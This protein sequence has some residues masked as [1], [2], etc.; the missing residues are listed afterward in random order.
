MP[1]KVRK[2]VGWS[3]VGLLAL[4]I[5]LNLE[6]VPIN[7]FFVVRSHMPVAVVIFLSAAMGAGAVY[8]FQFLRTY[9]KDK[10]PP[11]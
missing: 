10:P 7:F 6:S 11:G 1:P 4:F 3:L 5:L 9:R 8:A 2:I